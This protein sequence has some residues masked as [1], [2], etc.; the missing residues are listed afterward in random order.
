MAPAPRT[1]SLFDRLRG[2]FRIANRLEAVQL[3]L[4][5][6]SGMALLTRRSILLLETTGRRTG[7]QR[8]TPVAYWQEP[9]GDLII[10]GGAAGMTR[11]DWVANLRAHPDTAV[12]IRRR[13][14]SV[15]A[16]ELTGD[17]YEHV[18]ERAFER[19]PNAPK[20][21]TRSG[22][23]IPYFRLTPRPRRAP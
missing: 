17:E 14:I 10:G 7:R 6:T 3:R 13:R 12:W 8:R 22:R 11:V 9:D 2:L 15:S 5:G 1:P 18:R 20:Y 16:R 4:L 19:W 21:E 23:R